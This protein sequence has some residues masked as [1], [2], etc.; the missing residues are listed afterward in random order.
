MSNLFCFLLK[1]LMFTLRWPGLASRLVG[2]A[3]LAMPPSLKGTGCDRAC[4][5]VDIFSRPLR[6]RRVPWSS[7]SRSVQTTP[8]F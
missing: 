8:S 4:T 5:A 1:I 6:H 3:L 2:F 7:S